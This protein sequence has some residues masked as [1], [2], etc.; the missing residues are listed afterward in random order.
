M[1]TA[2]ANMIFAD[3]NDAFSIIDKAEPFSMCVS[4]IK[5][6]MTLGEFSHFNEVKVSCNERISNRII[7]GHEKN[8][9]KVQ[10]L[11][12]ITEVTL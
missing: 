1:C 9:L 8:K 5:A 2:I 10:L 4:A 12:S 3:A 6:K 7:I 11:G